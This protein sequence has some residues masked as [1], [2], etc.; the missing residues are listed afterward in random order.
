MSPRR[1]TAPAGGEDREYELFY[2]NTDGESGV[3]GISQNKPKWRY[4]AGQ[5]NRPHGGTVRGH[6][7]MRQM[8][9]AT[10][11]SSED[12][13]GKQCESLKVQLI[14]VNITQKNLKL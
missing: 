6:I 12:S 13:H 11:E 8:I 3:R 14:Q 2:L 7:Q 9:G 4:D 1:Q 5:K 10:E